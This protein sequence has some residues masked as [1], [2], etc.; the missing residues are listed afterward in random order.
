MLRAIYYDYTTELLGSGAQAYAERTPYFAEVRRLWAQAEDLARQT[1]RM[2][3]QRDAEI[4]E[5]RGRN[6][7]MNKTMAAWNRAMGHSQ[8][9]AEVE[10]LNERIAEHE[11]LLQQ[12]SAE[13][14]RLHDEATASPLTKLLKAY[15]E[16]KA[17]ERIEALRLHLLPSEEAA[18]AMVGAEVAEDAGRLAHLLSR[19]PPEERAEEREATRGRVLS[20]LLTTVDISEAEAISIARRLLIGQSNT[21][22]VGATL[23]EVN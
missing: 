2:K 8:G 9:A 11:L 12:A 10:V 7:M 14:A 1:R 21:E 19:L 20:A 17:S 15:D 13:V 5:L 18:M 3:S 23:A 6:E 4:A 22:L 16:C